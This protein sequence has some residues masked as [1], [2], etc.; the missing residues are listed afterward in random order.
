[1]RGPNDEQIGLFEVSDHYRPYLIYANG[2]HVWTELAYTT[3]EAI[4]KYLLFRTGLTT[5][6]KLVA[7]KA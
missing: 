2:C 4:E 6:N 5:T 3:S 1:M 7:R